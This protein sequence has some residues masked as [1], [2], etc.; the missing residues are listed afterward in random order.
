L[1]KLIHYSVDRYYNLTESTRLLTLA[2]YLLYFPTFISGPILKIQEYDATTNHKQTLKERLDLLL[3]GIKRIILGLFKTQVIIHFL[4]TYD[5]HSYPE[6][7]LLSFPL[8]KILLLMS[9]ST[10]NLYMNFS[11]YCDLVLGFSLCLGIKVPENF[12]Y[13]FISRNLQEFWQRWHITLSLWLKM[14]VFTPIYKNINSNKYGKQYKVITF[15]F[16]IFITF[17]L[18]GLWHGF[19]N[20]YLIYGLL[21]GGGL[22]V[23]VIWDKFL[24]KKKL[25]QKYLKSQVLKIM[26][27]TMT[28]FY[29]SFTLM[30]FNAAT[31]AKL[32][33]VWLLLMR[34]F[35]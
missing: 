2:N 33:L 22:A 20:N 7:F 6:E 23:N 1:L 17:F 18:M 11:G 9:I 34:P 10:I 8:G 32:K 3:I 35:Q 4:T 28:F 5:L 24:I 13:P 27:T 31:S 16:S 30:F 19:D 15:S 14:Y 29:F 25:K 26:A 21:Q 12:N